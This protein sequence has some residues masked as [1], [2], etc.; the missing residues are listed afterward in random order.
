MY[1]VSDT[2]RETKLRYVP[3]TVRRGFLWFEYDRPAKIIMEDTGEV[4]WINDSDCD[5][6]YKNYKLGRLHSYSKGTICKCKNT[7]LYRDQTDKII[8]PAWIEVVR[9]Y[10][11]SETTTEVFHFKGQKDF[12]LFWSEFKKYLPADSK[13]IKY[14]N[15]ENCD[16][17]F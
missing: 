11:N 12:D 14:N 6:Y 9:G 5:L 16:E 2:V 1:R 8:E 13:F 4:L 15:G 17:E 7:Y 10:D 3:K